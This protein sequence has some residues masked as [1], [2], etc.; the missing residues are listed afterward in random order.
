LAIGGWQFGNSIAQARLYFVKRI[1]PMTV[2]QLTFPIVTS[3]R[4]DFAIFI[5]SNRFNTGGAK[6]YA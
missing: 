1:G 3:T 5:N 4:Y 2:N 6:L